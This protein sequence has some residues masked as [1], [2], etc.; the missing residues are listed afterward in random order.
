[1]LKGSTL[2]RAVSDLAIRLECKDNAAT[3]TEYR[4]FRKARRD[5]YGLGCFPIDTLPA[6][7]ESAVDRYYLQPHTSYNYKIVAY[8]CSYADPY[9]ME[10]EGRTFPRPFVPSSLI[11]INPNVSKITG[12]ICGYRV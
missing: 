2:A 11:P 9:Y 5:T 1:M 6:N 12:V 4:V 3:E 8:N 7:I 10:A